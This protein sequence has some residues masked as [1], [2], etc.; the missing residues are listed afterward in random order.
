M[1][2]A[3]SK[4]WYG[5]DKTNFEEDILGTLSSPFRLHQMINNPNHISDTYSSCINLFFT[6]QPNLVVESDVHTSLHP[7]YHCQIIF[8]KFNLKIH[9][10]TLY[11]C[12]VWY[13]Q[14]MDTE[15]IRRA[16]DLFDWTKVF[17]NNSVR[18]KN[19][20]FNKIILN[21]LHNLI[22]HETLLVDDKDPPWFTNKMKNIINKKTQH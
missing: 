8:A 12:L 6:F 16:I 7:N 9:Y 11:Y 17:E 14:E 21:V 15:R 20:I 1:Q 3:K 13:Y 5:C 18:E 10:P 19:A 4:N 22:P 2:N